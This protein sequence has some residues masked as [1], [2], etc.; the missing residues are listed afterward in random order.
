MWTSLYVYYCSF[1][2]DVKFITIT[3]ACKENKIENPTCLHIDNHC[4]GVSKLKKK[5]T[6]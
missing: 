3:F 2:N 1:K 4:R 6:A 5:G